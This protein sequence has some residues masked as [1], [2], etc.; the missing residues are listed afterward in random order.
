MSASN[1]LHRS[2][3]EYTLKPLKTIDA[4]IECC[5]PLGG[6]LLAPGI[7][8]VILTAGGIGMSGDAPLYAGVALIVAG[9]VLVKLGEE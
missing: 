7:I 4:G 1:I 6:L 5:A 2:F 3:D 8:I 9:G